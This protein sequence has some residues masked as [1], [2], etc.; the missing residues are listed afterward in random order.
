MNI[1]IKN[2][3]KEKISKEEVKKATMYFLT[4]LIGEEKLKGMGKVSINFRK[5]SFNHGGKAVHKFNDNVN[6]KIVINSTYNRREILRVLAH[7]C[8]HVKQYFLKELQYSLMREGNRRKTVTL[9]KGK[10][11]LRSQYYN[12]AWE[13]E[14]RKF[15][16]LA[17]DYLNSENSIALIEKTIPEV[18]KT[19]NTIEAKILE[20]LKT[21]VE[22][23][24][25]GTMVI[26]GNPD[27][28]YTIDVL[29]TIY[30]MKVEGIIETYNVNGLIWARKK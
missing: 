24:N 7:E 29:K 21:D 12:R 1:T 25:L 20:V 17:Q 30:R 28:Q 3:P 16:S 2:T 9:W 13:V 10:R 8:T 15:E 5:L 18:Q 27:K 22:N 19:A 23:G 4:K 26:N 6:H 14:A 11:I